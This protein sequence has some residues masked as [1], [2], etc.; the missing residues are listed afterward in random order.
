[1]RLLN[2]E[3]KIVVVAIYFIEIL[4]HL[5]IDRKSLINIVYFIL[6]YAL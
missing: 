1:M 3:K 5:K 4:V 2:R 6:K